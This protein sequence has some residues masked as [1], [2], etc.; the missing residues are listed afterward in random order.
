MEVTCVYNFKVRVCYLNV[1]VTNKETE[2]CYN[3]RIWLK[4]ASLL[5]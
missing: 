2:S 4:K 1:Y 5:H 3:K